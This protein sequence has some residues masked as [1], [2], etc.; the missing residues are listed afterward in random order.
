MQKDCPACKL[1]AP[2][3]R[4]LIAEAA[5]RDVKSVAIV[6]DSLEEGRQYLRSLD[7][8]ADHVRSANLSSY[9]ISTI[10]TALVV[11]GAGVV[12]GVWTG[13]A[14]DRESE[15]RAKVVAVLETKGL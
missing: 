8:R 11:D 6:P 12:K 4:Q 1:A 7:L 13:A 9:K 10:P 15:T 14:P 5:K 3:Y 2:L